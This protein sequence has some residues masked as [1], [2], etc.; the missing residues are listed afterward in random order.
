SIALL[1]IATLLWMLSSHQWGGAMNY[2]RPYFAATL[3]GLIIHS[4]IGPLHNV[5]EGRVAA[6]IARIS[7]ALYIYHPLMVFGWMNA[8]SDWLRYLVKRP[9]SYVLTLMAAHA[10]TFWWEKHWQDLAKRLTA[11][12][13]PVK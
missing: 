9:V 2:A 13:P 7:Y 5:L 11:N 1:A 6:Y 4:H 12:R 3:V 8:G 10:S